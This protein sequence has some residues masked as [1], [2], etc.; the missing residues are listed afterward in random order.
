MKDL[1]EKINAIIEKLTKL[2]LD[3]MIEEEIDEEEGKEIAQYIL[4]E[5]RKVVDEL[6][7]EQF[8][9]NVA[10]QYPI[11]SAIINNFQKEKNLNDADQQKL[12]AIKSQLSKFINN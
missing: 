12:T 1:E 5:K 4:N 6:G 11:F 2:L 7:F 3:K 10:E 8:L 9:K